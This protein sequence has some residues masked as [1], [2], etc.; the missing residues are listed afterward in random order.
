MMRVM[1]QTPHT[2]PRA[3][4]PPWT[5]L[6]CTRA[7][8]AIAARE[9]PSRSRDSSSANLPLRAT[10]RLRES[11]SSLRPLPPPPSSHPLPRRRP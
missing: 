1:R 7:S 6:H 3:C 10:S 11:R 2:W 9:R 5:P 8:L 4:C